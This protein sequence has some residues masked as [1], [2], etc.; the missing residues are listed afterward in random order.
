MSS[1]FFVQTTF[2]QD[3]ENGFVWRGRC[4]DWG[5]I[6]PQVSVSKK[7]ISRQIQGTLAHWI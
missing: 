2:D 5:A 1:L 6:A 7:I 3:G 4:K